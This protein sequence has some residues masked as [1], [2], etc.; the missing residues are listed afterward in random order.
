MFA[1][2]RD[3]QIS[4]VHLK[5]S[6]YTM[7]SRICCFVTASNNGDSLFPFPAQ[8]LLSSLADDWLLTSP[9]QLFFVSGPAGTHEQIFVR[10]KTTYM[11]GNEASSLLIG[12]VGHSE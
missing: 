3:L 10:S 9:A 7:S 2:L 8:W 12:V 5:S 1:I 11:Q 6:Q 4:T